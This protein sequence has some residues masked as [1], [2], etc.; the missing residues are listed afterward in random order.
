[1]KSLTLIP[2]CPYPVDSGAKSIF[3]KHLDFLKGM[4]ECHVASARKRPVGTGWNNMYINRLEKRGFT[5]SLRDEGKFTI[6]YIIAMMYGSLFKGFHMEKAFGHSNLYHRYAFPED[7]WYS[8]TKSVNLAEIHYSYWAH[9]PCSCPKVIVV[10]DLWSDIMWEGDSK[11][12]RDLNTADLL[13][14]L[15]YTDCLKLVERGINNVHWS[16]PC[17]E[18]K[19]FPDSK[20][21]AIVGS[22]NRHNREGMYW[23]T[24][25]L[26]SNPL[27]SGVQIHCY[28]GISRHIKGDVGLFPEG[29]YADSSK[30]YAECGIVLM[31][32]VGGTGIQIKGIEA[33]ANGRA[34]IARK[35]AMRGLPDHEKGWCEVDTV[36]EMVELLERVSKDQQFR[37]KL[38][39]RAR[40]Y[41]RKYLEKNNI[42][43]ELH[44]KYRRICPS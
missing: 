21:V 41:Y 43:N 39:D 25:H 24:K 1:M 19:T 3:V 35:G 2:Y 4:G 33:L 9:L 12:T 15:S 27:P 29:K 17:L 18:E 16:P 42:L 14:T 20:K 38:M 22:E 40:S 44:E 30:P 13:V 37:H 11:E 7:W 6:K 8:Q 34:V 31:L 28:G 5:V 23:L 26:R 36:E 10:H 32:T